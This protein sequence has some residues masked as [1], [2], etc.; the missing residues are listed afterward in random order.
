MSD[1]L[2]P[3]G[4]LQARLLCPPLPLRLRSNSGMLSRWCY[5]TIS[6]SAAPLSF[7]FQSSPGSG[8]SPVTPD[9]STE[10]SKKVSKTQGL[11]T[12]I[13]SLQL[14]AF[15]MLNALPEADTQCKGGGKRGTEICQSGK[16]LLNPSILFGKRTITWQKESSKSPGIHSGSN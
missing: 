1:S 10:G 8:S 6:S 4:L 15:S 3:H 9:T 16:C 7:C 2:W 14:V 12:R 13:N 5:L 11:K